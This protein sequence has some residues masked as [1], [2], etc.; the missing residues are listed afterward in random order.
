MPKYFAYVAVVYSV[1]WVVLL[2]YLF[3][4]GSRLSKAEQQI[5]VMNDKKK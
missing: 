4:I 2:V 3:S 1:I 5:A